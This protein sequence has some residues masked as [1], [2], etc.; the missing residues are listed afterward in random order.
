MHAKGHRGTDKWRW[1]DI[2]RSCILND[3]TLVGNLAW[4]DGG[5]AFLSDI[6]EKQCNRPNERSAHV[7]TPTPGHGYESGDPYPGFLPPPVAVNAQGE[8][9]HDRAVVFVTEHSIKG[10]QRHPLEYAAPL[11]VRT[12]NESARITFGTDEQGK[13][14]P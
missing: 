12:G 1:G 2:N 13:E 5:G 3:C 11:L 14:S 6:M 7:G 10:T 9:P 4:S 8:A